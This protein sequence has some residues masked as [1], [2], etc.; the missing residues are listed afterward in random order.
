MKNTH[1]YTNIKTISARHSPPRQERFLSRHMPACAQALC[2][3]ATAWPLFPLALCTTTIFGSAICSRTL[4]IP[5]Q[6][7]NSL[8]FCR[9]FCTAA[10]HSK[11]DAIRVWSSL[12]RVFL[13]II[14]GSNCRY[15]SDRMKSGIWILG[16]TKNAG[17]W[18]TQLIEARQ[19]KTRKFQ[20]YFSRSDNKSNHHQSR[21]QLDSGRLR[22]NGASVFRKWEAQH[23]H[24]S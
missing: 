22:A 8:F 15:H 13:V 9:V 18:T 6:V 24:P 20:N 3:S 16:S 5:A 4:M 12:Y 17:F 10:N 11:H 14:F 1:A 19:E 7:N 2:P 23:G 21:C